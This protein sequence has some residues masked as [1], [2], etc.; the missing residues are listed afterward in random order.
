MKRNSIILSFI[1]IF[2]LLFTSLAYAD[3]DLD[4]YGENLPEYK[5]LED[6]DEYTVAY[7]DLSPEQTIQRIS[8]ID[9]INLEKAEAVYQADFANDPEI[10]RGSYIDREYIVTK[11][12]ASVLGIS[13]KVELGALCE[14]SVGQGSNFHKIKKTWSVAESGY[15]TWDEIYNN[16]SLSDSLT[17]NLVARGTCTVAVDSS[18]T[19]AYERAGF[20]LSYSTGGTY[21]YRK[22]ATLEHV[23]KLSHQ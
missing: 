22:N 13:Y 8:E 4:T 17:L 6:T 12:V 16:S 15:H 3:S 11:K 23:I 14:M 21:Y 7:R 1:L 18:A 10:Y 2:M 19:A 9:N 5:V 20:S